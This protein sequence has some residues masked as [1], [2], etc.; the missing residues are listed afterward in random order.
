MIR[1]IVGQFIN[2]EELIAILEDPRTDAVELNFIAIDQSLSEDIIRRYKSILPWN[3]IS[4]YQEMSEEF[5]MEFIN[6]INYRSLKNNNR[7]SKEVKD[8]VLNLLRLRKF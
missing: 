6:N 8:P 1:L 4:K 7:I 5:M 2:K 3:L